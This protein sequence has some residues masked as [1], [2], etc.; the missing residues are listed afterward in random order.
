M[1]DVFDK[2]GAWKDYRIAKAT[3]LYPYFRPIEASHASTEVEIE[4]RRVVMVGVQQLPGPGR[5]PARQGSGD[6]AISRY[7]TT[8]SGSRLLNGTLELH[9][10]LEQPLRQVPQPR[11]GAGLLHRLPDQP[12][13][14]VSACS[15]A[16]TSSSPTGNH[17]S[18][19]DGVRLVLRRGAKRTAT[20]TWRISRQLLRGGRPRRGQA[21]RHRRRLL[22]GGR[23]RATSRDR[24]ARAAVPRPGD[25]GRRPRHGRAG[26][27]RARHRGALR[28]G[29]QTDLV[30]G[31]FSK[32]FA[33]LGGVI[34]GTVRRHRLD[35]A[36]G[37]RRSS[38]APR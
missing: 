10:E 3:G 17:A 1:S 12:G 15:A 8:C 4:G 7:G 5:R 32:S 38:S 30:M 24:G 33:S 22:D 18:L 9:E 13:D 21:H 25:D 14:A 28:P 19:V 34:A 20:T 23:P 26:R 27:A 31:T 16:T 2:C 37:A 35:Q 29:G 36:Q 6:D 11:G